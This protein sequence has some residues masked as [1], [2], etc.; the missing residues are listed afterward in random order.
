MEK[1]L[2][3]TIPLDISHANSEII[4]KFT[5]EINEEYWICKATDECI[6]DMN[7]LLTFEKQKREIEFNIK[8]GQSKNKFI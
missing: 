5:K 7:R 6:T 2:Y 1:V 4:L 8:S 3:I